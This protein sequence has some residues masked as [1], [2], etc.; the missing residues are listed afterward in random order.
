MATSQETDDVDSEQETAAVLTDDDLL[1]SVGQGLDQL[2]RGEI[3]SAEAVRSAMRE[4]R[5]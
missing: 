2:K 5:A 1:K 3:F 4:A